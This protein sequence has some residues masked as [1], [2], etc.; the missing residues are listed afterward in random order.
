MTTPTSI[1]FLG[2][3]GYIGG[4]ILVAF[5]KSFPSPQYSY[6]AL[7]RS[8]KDVPAL[9]KLGVKVLQGSHADLSLIRDEA[10]KSDIVVNLADADDLPLTKAILEG[11]EKKK[12][13]NGGGLPILLHTSGTGVISTAK[14]PGELTSAEEKIWN[15]NIPA[16]IRAIA[17][18]QPH[19]DVDLEILTA[20][21]RGK[22]ATYIIAPSTIYGVAHSNPV[23]KLSIQIPTVIRLA[24]EHKQALHAGTGTNLWNNVHIDDLAELYVLVFQNAL[25]NP[26]AKASPYESYYWG[27]AAEHS[28]GDVTRAVGASLHKRGLL[29]TAEP[30]SATLEEAPKLLYVA[31]N[32]RAVAER[33]LALG[34]KPSRIGWEKYLEEDIDRTLVELKA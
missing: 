28:W 12:E 7:V 22:V 14:K 31:S 21:E 16:D 15:D 11:L 19:R 8:S 13:R 24:L 27:A 18:T 1:F 10:A 32:S 4:A 33:G 9:E 20:G 34:W 29:P 26:T 3:T 17:P 30:R 2:A 6:T 23:R 5:L 25:K